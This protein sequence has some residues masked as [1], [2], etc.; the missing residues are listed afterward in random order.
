MLNKYKVA[1]VMLV[2][3]M[4]TCLACMIGCINLL[5]GSINKHVLTNLAKYVKFLQNILKFK[6]RC[7]V[8]M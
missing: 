8:Y 5:M 3:T 1:A 2:N 6:D 7:I 4:L